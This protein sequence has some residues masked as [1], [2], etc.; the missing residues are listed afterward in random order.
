[1]LLKNLLEFKVETNPSLKRKVDYYFTPYNPGYL[2]DKHMK[3]DDQEL[4]MKNKSLVADKSQKVNKD[5]AEVPS[6]LGDV[7]WSKL[8]KKILSM[9]TNSLKEMQRH[10]Q[11]QN[12]TDD[13]LTKL[14][15]IE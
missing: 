15:L 7:H 10:V 8:V 12:D 6:A 3:F 2:M 4:N 1:M 14:D 13:F 5:I 9:E 11:M